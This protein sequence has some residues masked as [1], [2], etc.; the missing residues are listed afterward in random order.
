MA[1]SS[2]ED[3]QKK[4]FDR[5]KRRAGSA[6][7]V[8]KQKT[9]SIIDR[10][11]GEEIKTTIEE[12]VIAQVEPYY[13]KLYL[14][15][16]SYLKNIQGCSELMFELLKNMTYEGIIILNSSI[17]RI[18][19]SE[20]NVS[21]G[22]IDNQLSKIVKQGVFFRVDRGV[23]QPNP[24]LF[25]RGDWT[26]IRELRKKFLIELDYNSTDGRVVRFHI[27]DPEGE[28]R[29]KLSDIY[30]KHLESKTRHKFEHDD[31][32]DDVDDV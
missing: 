30:L 26:N 20:L 17:K 1:S 14:E 4:F 27:D 21:V 19:A 15:D 22:H 2:K 23:F 13:V 31:D 29:K 3:D 10:E 24:Y 5:T 6:R 8:T 7:R 32:D 28:S 11:T 18:I 25:G 12:D 9:T 16:L